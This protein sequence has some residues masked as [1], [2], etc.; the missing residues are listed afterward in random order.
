MIQHGSHGSRR[1]GVPLRIQGALGAAPTKLFP[2]LLDRFKRTSLFFLKGKSPH[3]LTK[4]D[5]ALLA[6]AL[7][8]ACSFNIT[9]RSFGVGGI[10]SLFHV[11]PPSPVFKWIISVL[12]QIFLNA[13]SSQTFSDPTPA[14]G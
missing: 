4:A 5:K 1:H 6:K 7:P 10:C 13:I 8:A 12:H 2:S 9:N 14:T 3:R 11:G